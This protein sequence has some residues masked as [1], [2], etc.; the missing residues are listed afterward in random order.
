[1]TLRECFS[2]GLLKKIPVEPAKT[3]NSFKL[4]K[5]FLGRA[6]GTLKAKYFDV[7][8]LMAYNCMFHVG[9]GLLFAKGYKERSHFCMTM[10]LLKEFKGNN[11]ITDCLKTMDSYRISRHAIQ[12]SGEA[13]SEDDAREAVNDAKIFLNTA[14]GANKI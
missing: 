1:M 9:R 13:C 4:A 12:Y 2:K 11:K 5:H 14:R 8:F 6:E 3:S 10:L 7:S